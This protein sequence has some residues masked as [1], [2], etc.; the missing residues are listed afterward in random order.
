[1]TT[2]Q[3]PL[4]VRF[5][6]AEG[7]LRL[8]LLTGD[9]VRDVTGAFESVAAFLRASVGRVDAAI[10][11]VQAAAEQ[12]AQ[13]YPAARFN[14]PPAPGRDHWL[15]PVDTQDVWAAGVTYARSRS[16][17]QEEAVDGG[18]IYARVYAAERPELFFKAHGAR[19]VGPLDTVGIRADAAWNVPEPELT[20]LLNPAL[21]VVGYT[22]GNDM[23]SRDIEGANPLY[24]PQ[25]KVYNRSCALGP[26][27]AL[28]PLAAW[29]DTSIGVTVARDGA[30]VF[31][32]AVHTQRIHRTLAELVAYLGRSSS[33]P[34]GAALLTG[35]GIVPPNDFT[36]Q[37]GD[38][39]TVTIDGV[40]AL[41]NT[42]VKV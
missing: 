35:T 33:Y 28:M 30:A 25:A 36:L 26:G 19:V 31:A 32:D 16:A 34:D 23:S 9:T 37:P 24:L 4:L 1:M 17:R 22:A 6:L 38:I 10:A 7:G 29:P 14:Q 21:E 5:Y 41:V 3:F 18:D 12:A 13:S 11:E 8:G 42:V 40:G 27:V 20:L 2:T 15:A 39:V